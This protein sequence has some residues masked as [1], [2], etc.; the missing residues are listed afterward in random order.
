M[1]H[2]Q[3]QQR[4]KHFPQ[5]LLLILVKNVWILPIFLAILIA[6]GLMLV[7]NYLQ[8]V[9]FHKLSILPVLLQ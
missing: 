6:A 5:K 2:H 8:R 1:N 4:R 7:H 9:I 3:Q